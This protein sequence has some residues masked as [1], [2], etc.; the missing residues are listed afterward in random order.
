MI[1]NLEEKL[2]LEGNTEELISIVQKWQGIED[3]SIATCA[4][5]EG[6]TKD[7]LIRLIIDSLRQDALLIREVQQIMIARFRRDAN[8]LSP[9]ELGRIWECLDHHAEIEKKTIAL[10]EKARRTCLLSILRELLASLMAH[11][12]S[13]SSF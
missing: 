2:E 4:E 7:P 3:M 1:S 12:K 9:T 11:E 8:G 10:A 5:I 13:V 6:K